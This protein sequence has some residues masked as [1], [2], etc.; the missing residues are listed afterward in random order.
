MFKGGVPG[1]GRFPRHYKLVL[2]VVRVEGYD[3]FVVACDHQRSWKYYVEAVA[4]PDRFKARK[5]GS[6]AKYA[7]KYMCDDEYANMGDLETK[8]IG[9]FYLD[10]NSS[11]PYGVEKEGFSK[12]INKF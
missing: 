3:F 10:T 8:Q 6:W 2:F 5:C 7:T 9:D 11:P 4:N 12:L 1:S